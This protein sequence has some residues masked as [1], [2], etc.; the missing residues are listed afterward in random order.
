MLPI[1][2]RHSVL[3]LV[4]LL[5]NKRL[6]PIKLY[7]ITPQVTI[8]ITH[9]GVNTAGDTYTLECYVNG[10][11]STIIQWLDEQGTPVFSDGS[12]AITNSTPGSFLHFSPLQQ[13]HE[14]IYTCSAG[15]AV[16]QSAN[17]SVNGTDII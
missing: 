10:T 7:V 17:L 12:R 16:S 9:S 8:T 4:S 13:S 14:G 6:K 3:T 5:A 2:S 1:L 11:K 15:A